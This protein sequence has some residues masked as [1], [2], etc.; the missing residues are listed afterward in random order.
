[1]LELEVLL[2]DVKFNESVLS[3]SALKRCLN[4]LPVVYYVTK[5][6]WKKSQFLWAGVII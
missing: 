6:L 1:M 4:A 3:Y 2:G 5:E